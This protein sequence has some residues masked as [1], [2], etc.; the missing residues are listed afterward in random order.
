MQDEH[1]GGQIRLDGNAA[2]G[3]LDELFC[4]ETSTAIAVCAGCGAAAPVGQLMVYAL[5]M[6]AILRCPGCDNA[7]LRIGATATSRWLD[8][9][10][11]TVLRFETAG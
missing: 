8:T 4:F 6:G 1:A 7:I 2:A 10:G 5:E 3:V 9:R 11:A